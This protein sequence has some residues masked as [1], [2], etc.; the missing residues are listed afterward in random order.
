MSKGYPHTI[1]LLAKVLPEPD[2][3]WHHTKRIRTSD[4][5]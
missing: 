3:S 5:G 4:F 1:Q 2:V